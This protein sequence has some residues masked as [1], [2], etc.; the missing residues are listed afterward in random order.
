M[1]LSENT[2]INKH[3]IKLVKG[4]QP[5][6]SSI[7]SLDPVEM[8]TLKAYIETYLKTGF[9]W[10]SKFPADTP[11]LFEKKPDGSLHLCINYQSFNNLTIKNQYPLPLI[12]K[13][14]DQ[15]GRAK[16]FTELDLTNAYYGMRIRENNKWKT[17]FRTRYSL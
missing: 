14:L 5:S 6:Y 15:L 11:I 2:G 3:V 4:K 9:I 17:T 8:E 12:G 16:Q 7:Y 10:P 1:E 13:S